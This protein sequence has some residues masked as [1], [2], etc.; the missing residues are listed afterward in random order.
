[1]WVF[2][3]RWTRVV[4]G[5]TLHVYLDQGFHAYRIE[6]LRLLGLNAPEMRGDTREAG[7]KARQFVI[8]WLADADSSSLE[9]SLIIQTEKAD[10]FGRYL[11]TIWRVVDGACL[12]DD[13]LT[14]GNAVPF[15]V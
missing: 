14:S 13:L 6:N 5:D 10:A 9:W 7:L 1:M 3:A 15:M 8:D 4:D 2:R 12:N 11:A